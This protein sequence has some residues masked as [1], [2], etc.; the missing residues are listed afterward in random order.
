[1]IEDTLI[2]VVLAVLFSVDLPP[3]PAPIICDIGLVGEEVQE[4]RSWCIR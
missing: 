4:I 2:A 3:E 1:V